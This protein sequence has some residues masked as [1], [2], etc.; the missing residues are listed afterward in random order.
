M[1]RKKVFIFLLYSFYNLISQI[2]SSTTQFI[3][4][5][6]VASLKETNVSI[7]KNYDIRSNKSI[8]KPLFIIYK[9]IFSEQFAATCAFNP[10]CSVFAIKS[11]QSKGLIKGFLLAL[12][13]LTRCTGYAHRENSY[14][15]HDH[16]TDLINDTPDMY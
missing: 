13:R 3:L 10:S 16:S 7:Q 12:D 14:L 4:N 11:I 6:Q 8:I 15:H 5:K 1:T 2:D 9:A